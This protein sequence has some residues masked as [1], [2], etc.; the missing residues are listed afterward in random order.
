MSR[1]VAVVGGG[2][3]GLFLATL[4]RRARS[5]VDVTLFERNQS[6]DAF[7]FGVVFSDATLRKIDEADPVLRDALTAHGRHWDRIDVWSEGER[8]GFSGNGMAAIH[9][10]VLL[11]LLQ[12]NAARAGVDLRFGRVA[13]PLDELSRDFDVVVGADGTNSVVREHLGEVGH[14]VDTATAKFIW[15]GTTHLF[16]GL[17]FVHRASEHGNFAVHG[18]PISDDLSTFIVETDERTWRAAG[19]DAFDVSQPPGV[20]DTTS[21]DY[22]EKLFAEDIGGASLVANNSRWGNFRTRRTQR[23]YRGNVVMLGD[24]VHTAHFSVGSGTKMAMEDAVALAEQITAAWR[25]DDDLETALEQYQEERAR[26]V[27]KIQ[28]AARPS[29][30]W[31]ER[32]GRYQRELDPLTF[33]F[34]FFSRSIGVAKIAQRDAQLVADVRAG[35]L[36]HHGQPA[37]QATV[38]LPEGNAGTLETVLLPAGRDGE[39]A[40]VR[41]RRGTQ[42]RLVPSGS[43]AAASTSAYDVPLVRAPDDEKGLAASV[44]ALP[45]A[46]LVAITGDDELTKVLLSEEARWGRGLTVVLV[47]S[48]DA[49]AAETLLLSARADVVVMADLEDAR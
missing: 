26:S 45:S 5:D 37:L 20:S 42:L 44:D 22:L 48:Y 4:L 30:A 36:A 24:A 19:L 46:G 7:G 10:R 23:W 15:F 21:Q 34:H 25:G 35:W 3:G 13:P 31:W 32:F 33:S 28:D 1:R 38:P 43:D 17:T 47:G 16:D 29:L 8:H 40:L 6:T 49:D 11:K 12:E 41:D 14:T 27:A 39:L 9:R 2:P 18:Y